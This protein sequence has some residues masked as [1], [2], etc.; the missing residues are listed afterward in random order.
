M[1]VARVRPQ[2]KKEENSTPNA[3]WKLVV[4]SPKQTIEVQ[5]G[6]KLYGFNF[7]YA[8]DGKT[9]QEEVFTKVASHAVDWV[10]EGFNS[11][12]FTYGNTSS[13]KSFTMFGHENGEKNLRGIIPRACEA[14]FAGIDS[15]EDVV[16]ASVKCSF[17]EIYRERIRDL[18]CSD[19]DY[20]PDL[21]IRQHPLKGTYVQGLI[22]KFVY[23]PHDILEAIKEGARQRSTA[24]TALNAVSSRSHAVLTLALSQTLADGSEILSKLHLIDLAGSENVEKSEA[25]GTTLA[26][27]QTINKSLSCLGNVIYALTEKNRDHIPYR[28]SKL[29]YILQDSLG[30]NSKTILIVTASPSYLS[31]SETLSTFRFA[32][33]A[34]QIVNIPKVNKNESNINLLKTIDLLNKR[35]AELEAKC[36][37]SRIV[38]EAVEK[39]NED[40]KEVQLF[41]TKCERLEKKIEGL[42]AQLATETRRAD[43]YKDIFEKQRH[44][45]QNVCNQLYQEKIALSIAKNEL[46]QY[47]SFCAS[48]KGID[49]PKILEVAVQRFKILHL[50]VPPA[51]PTVVEAD[52]DSPPPD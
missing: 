31:S 25:Q 20:N 7:D 23:T 18:L 39:A 36:E 34:K 1:V 22:E 24:S 30:G 32:Q 8:F 50:D 13:G 28:D 47:R 46:E 19:S 45:A 4:D 9:S 37:D 42:T 33:R 16:E 48:L 3:S 52:L 38:I 35:I 27:A 43:S 12:I 21:R 44:L 17:L 14:L 40:T 26:E 10:C 51:S 49:N 41:K 2:N 6:G 15:R 5:E 29:T 11:T